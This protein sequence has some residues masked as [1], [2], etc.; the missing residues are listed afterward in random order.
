MYSGSLV[1][2]YDFNIIIHAAK[3]L[4]NE[5]IKFIIRGKGKLL[6]DIE[7]LIKEL[8]VNNVMHQQNYPLEL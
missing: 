3:K 2:S 5:K 1:E 7:K 4:Q 8:K 6:S